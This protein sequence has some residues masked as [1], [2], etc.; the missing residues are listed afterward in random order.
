MRVFDYV[1]YAYD[2]ST[3]HFGANADP[4]LVWLRMGT[5]WDCGACAA[6]WPITL[7]MGGEFVPFASQIWM[8]GDQNDEGY[9]ADP[10][11]AHELGHW[12]MSQF[13]TSPD[14]GG[15][16]T[17][18]CPTFPGQAWSEGW[19]TGFSSILRDS[20]IYYDKQEQSMFWLDVSARSNSSNSIWQRPS[21]SHP[22]GLL[23]KIDENE[24]AAMLW[25]LSQFFVPDST[26]F[27]ALESPQMNTPPWGRSYTGHTWAVANGCNHA[28]VV[29]LGVSKPMFADFLDALRCS[30]VSAASIDAVTEP[31]KHYPYPSGAPLCP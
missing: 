14:E 10:V 25:E 26:L 28:D 29:D 27:A 11:T 19:A 16:H 22:E 8:P 6:R 15:A 4:L 17:V 5:S 12:A 24:V 9:W 31:A 3:F 13:G 2:F 23:Q 21:A 18:G 1:R 20:P 30:G 7:D